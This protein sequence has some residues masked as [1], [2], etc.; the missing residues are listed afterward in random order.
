MMCPYY[1]EFSTT[2]TWE[3]TLVKYF[4][5][6][7]T[8]PFSI[9]FSLAHSPFKMHSTLRDRYDRACIK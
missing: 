2:E 1:F 4:P 8:D 6:I 3:I 9:A 7:K 5:K